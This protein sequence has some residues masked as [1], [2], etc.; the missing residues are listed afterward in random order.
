MEVL[1]NLADWETDFRSTVREKL[2]YADPENVTTVATN[3]PQF[4]LKVIRDYDDDFFIAFYDNYDQKVVGCVELIDRTK[5]YLNLGSGKI[6]EPHS[7]IAEA[8]RGHGYI[9]QVYRWLLDNGVTL[10]T[11]KNQTK[12]SNG[13]WKKIGKDEA[14]ELQGYDTMCHRTFPLEP[15][16]NLELYYKRMMLRRKVC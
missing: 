3:Y 15:D 9:E 11:G 6:F 7:Y 12:C 13:M 14:Y 5:S 10:V 8:Y 2:H 4:S 1:T 16:T